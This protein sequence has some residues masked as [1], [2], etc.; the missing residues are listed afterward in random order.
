VCYKIGIPLQEVLMQTHTSRRQ[1]TQLELF[2]P[3]SDAIQWHK[4]PREIQQRAVTLLASLLREYSGIPHRPA[5]AKEGS[6]E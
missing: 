3:L 5:K 6:H 2:R 4:L 1:G